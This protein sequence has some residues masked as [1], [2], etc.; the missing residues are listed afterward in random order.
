MRPGSASAID[1][2]FG[3]VVCTCCRICWSSSRVQPCLPCAPRRHD[4]PG[5]PRAAGKR[6]SAGA[7]STAPSSPC[8]T[9][10]PGSCGAALDS[11]RTTSPL[12]PFGAA[13][14]GCATAGEGAGGYADSKSAAPLVSPF[15]SALVAAAPCPSAKAATPGDATAAA[16]CRA[17]DSCGS[18]GIPGIPASCT[19]PRLGVGTSTGRHAICMPAGTVPIMASRLAICA[20]TGPANPMLCWG[21]AVGAGAFA[22]SSAREAPR[23]R[24]SAATRCA[25]S[26]II[27]GSMLGSALDAASLWANEQQ[28]CARARPLLVNFVHVESDAQLQHV[29]SS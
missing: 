23:A 3:P 25:S 10:T 20:A 13:S 14:L 18:C 5:S 11:A 24:R 2:H 17:G 12:A 26:A 22:P 27:G 7:P 6:S 19:S 29:K 8:C 1:D 9:T 4:E 15:A 21:A 28:V 16:C